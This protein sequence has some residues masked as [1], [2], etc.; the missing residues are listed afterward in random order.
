VRS[1]SAHPLHVAGLAADLGVDTYRAYDYGDPVLDVGGR[2]QRF[3]GPLPPIGLLAL[4]ELVAVRTRLMRAAEQLPTQEPWASPV[5]RQANRVPFA[6]WVERSV[7]TRVA[8]GLVRAGCR[9]VLSTEP[10]V[11]STLH[12]LSLVQVAGG[13]VPLLAGE[14]GAHE[15]RFVGGSGQLTARLAAELGDRVHLGQHVPRIR[16]EVD[17]HPTH[18]SKATKTFVASTDGRLKLYTLPGYSP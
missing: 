18:R 15:R 1:S 12:V 17:G 11:A 6:T 16:Q 13:V 9:M 5:G 8:R 14:G 4:A 3:R 2:H 7:R 10:E